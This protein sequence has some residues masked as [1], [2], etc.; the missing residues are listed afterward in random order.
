MFGFGSKKKLQLVSPLTGT[1]VALSEVPDPAFSTK[2]LGDGIAIEPT[3]GLVKAPCDGNVMVLFPTC[4]AVG[5]RTKEGVELLIHLGIDTVE[6]KGEPFEGLVRQGDDVK[7][8][9]SLIRFDPEK[10]R[11]GGRAT[12]SPFVVTNGDRVK[13]LDVKDGPYTAGETPI[14]EIEL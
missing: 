2:I 1:Q 10:I 6:L 3:E 11:A 8:G 12:V 7:R 9:Q 4:H 5:I 14:M 13:S